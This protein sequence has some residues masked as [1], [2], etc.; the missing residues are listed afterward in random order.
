MNL[1]VKDIPA[2]L[3]PIL[4]R[5]RH[6]VVI[7]FFI[8]LT[9]TYGFLILRINEL[10]QGEPDESAIQEKLKTAPRPKLDDSAAK[11][12][13]ELEVQSIEV[14]TLFKDAREN[15]FLECDS[16]VQNCR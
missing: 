4:S 11:K 10:T 16:T 2:K 13:K 14:Q 3:I 12:I 15:P 5:L 8:G 9:A 6:Y 7:F 1:E